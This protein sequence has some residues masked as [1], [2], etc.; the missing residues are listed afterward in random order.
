VRVCYCSPS[1]PLR[2]GTSGHQTGRG[3]ADAAHPVSIC[4]CVCVC[5]CESVCA[6]E[7]VYVI[8]VP[9]VLYGTAQAATRQGKA[10]QTQLILCCISMLRATHDCSKALSQLLRA[11]HD[12]S[13]ALTM[14]SKRSSQEKDRGKIR[15]SCEEQEVRT[16]EIKGWEETA[17]KHR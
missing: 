7:C 10:Q 5:V 2:H 16:R 17:E 14:C 3:T 8:A 9:P 6:C 12:C 15:L 4:V 11:T 13:K 1:S